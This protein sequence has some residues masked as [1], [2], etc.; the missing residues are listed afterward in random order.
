MAGSRWYIIRFPRNAVH[1]CFRQINQGDTLAE[2]EINLKV[3]REITVPEVRL[4]DSEGKQVGVV[5]LE[6]ALTYAEESQ[7][8]LVEIMPN[9][10]PSVCKLLDYGKHK[11][12]ERKKRHDAKTKQKQTMVKEVKFR[13]STGDGDYQT[14]IR[15]VMRFLEVGDKVKVSLWFRGREIVKSQ[16]GHLVLER[17]LKDVEHIADVEQESKLEGKRLQMM[18]APRRDSSR[19]RDNAQNEDK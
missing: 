6:R 4:I 14:K 12:R 10:T 7:L 15:N 1:I 3:N 11:Y 17:V 5:S 16:R 19:K 9:V 2:K 18:L 8:D 13:L